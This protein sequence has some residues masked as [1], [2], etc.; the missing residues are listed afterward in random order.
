[1]LIVVTDRIETRHIWIVQRYTQA[2]PLTKTIRLKTWPQ[3]LYNL[4]GFHAGN[5]SPLS[6]RRLFAGLIR[7]SRPA[8]CSRIL[9]PHSYS[10]FLFRTL[11]ARLDFAPRTEAVYRSLTNIL[12]RDQPA[13]RLS[14]VVAPT[15]AARQVKMDGI[16]LTKKQ[17][18]KKKRGKLKICGEGE[19]RRETRAGEKVEREFIFFDTCQKKKYSRLH[20]H[21]HATIISFKGPPAR[22][23]CRKCRPSSWQDGPYALFACLT[24]IP[25]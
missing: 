22:R 10:A 25:S 15:Q 19:K 21:R 6:R 5:I 9:V 17:K 1:M 4:G 2:N 14:V 24:P 7:R 16:Q 3:C 23:R 18:K 11:F 20:H 12:H 8:L 13:A